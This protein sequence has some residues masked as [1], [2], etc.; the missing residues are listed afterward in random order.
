MIKRTFLLFFIL[1]VVGVLGFTLASTTRWVAA[2]DFPTSSP[3]AALSLLPTGT[4]STSPAQL[5]PTESPTVFFPPADTPIPTIPSTPL[6]AVVPLI[7][8]Q[9]SPA[10]IG[11]SSFPSVVNPLTGLPVEQ[12]E[13][14]D[15]RPMAIK[16]TNYPRSV[17]PQAGLS[18]ADIVY[19]YLLERGITRF[20]GIFYGQEAEKVGPVRSGRFFD[21]HLFT[22]YDAIFVFGNADPRVIDHFMTLGKY[23]INSLVIEIDRDKAPDC[24][25]RAA[26][27]L[28]RDRDIESYNSLFA[29]T[30]ELTEYINRRNG[31]HRPDLDGM[32]FS[33]Q[34]PLNGEIA[35]NIFT[36]YSL[37]IYN[38]WEYSVDLGQY[39]RFQE[40][41]GYADAREETY[42]VHEDDLTG[43]QL[44]ADNVVV[45][46][47]PHEYFIKTAT[48]EI[49][50]IH[51]LGR[52]VGYVFRDGYAYPVIW[53]RPADGGIVQLFTPDGEYFPLKP[54]STWYQIIS[55]ESTFSQEN[56]IDWRFT[57]DPPEV[58]DEP[59]NPEGAIFP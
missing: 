1:F 42:A 10:L 40:T 18:R 19:E 29:D 33:Y 4:S 22:M 57:F 3:S 50:Q 9:S 24:T 49:Y 59:I 17:R 7:V 55:E 25:D 36:R 8:N 43:Q 34:P 14:L 44:S 30:A 6:P 45:L 47:V 52:G 11:P 26:Y 16:V 37:F 12:F 21:E 28:C 27:H 54:G 38:K 46:Y 39:L 23:V 5:D 20:V 53:E 31:N 56:G 2:V 48:T 51:L 32:V 15:R 35:F 41:L 13:L 58:P